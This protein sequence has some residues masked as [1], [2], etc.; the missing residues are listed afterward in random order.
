MLLGLSLTH[1]MTWLNTLDAFLEEYDWVRNIANSPLAVRRRHGKRML[2]QLRVVLLLDEVLD[3]L[4]TSSP[5][6]AD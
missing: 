2:Q 1:A 6:T 3:G 4:T 5:T